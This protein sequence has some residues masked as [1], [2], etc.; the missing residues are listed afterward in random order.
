MKHVLTTVILNVAATL[1]TSA[2]GAL[3]DMPNT[4]PVMSQA[5]TVE[6]AQ[7][8]MD[9][10]KRRWDIAQAEQQNRL[11]AFEG[12]FED[13]VRTD[14]ILQ[15]VTWPYDACTDLITLIPPPSRG[16]GVRSLA[17]FTT[18]PVADEHAQ[19]SLVTYD[20]NLPSSDEDFFKSERS[21]FF[22]LS[23]DPSHL[24]LWD[25]VYSNP[26]MRDMTYEPGPYGYPVRKMDGAVMLGNVAVTISA[27]HP[28]DQ[29]HYLAKMIRC[30]I[31]GGLLA[32]G[33]DPTILT[34]DLADGMEDKNE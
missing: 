22:N 13:F 28:E 4:Q 12:N 3:A 7:A 6:N 16:W 23:A 29:A 15:N 25:M 14:P 31:D 18:N 9:D 32:N 27:T 10:V 30:A 33:V 2:T 20:M 11:A 21:V 34:E 5:Y 24:M 19:F 1:C 8:A 17:P 26:D